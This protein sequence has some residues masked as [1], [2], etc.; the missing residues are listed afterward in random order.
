MAGTSWRLR[1]LEAGGILCR[2]MQT[3]LMDD[4]SGITKY[5]RVT[6]HLNRF[7]CIPAYTAFAGFEIFSSGMCHVPNA[8]LIC[9][10]KFYSRFPK[11]IQYFLFYLDVACSN[12]VERFSRSS[13]E[14]THRKKIISTSSDNKF[15]LP[16]IV[17]SDRSIFKYL[18]SFVVARSNCSIVKH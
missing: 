13:V 1:A 2:G 14:I 16:I 12:S 10:I 3:G 17:R 15:S 9:V 4:T 11:R 8:T 5:A 6:D 7:K 18:I